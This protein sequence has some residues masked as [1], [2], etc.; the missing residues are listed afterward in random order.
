MAGYSGYSMSNNAIKAYD[1]GKLPLSKIT[2]KTL[3]KFNI[4]ISVEMFKWICQHKR[5]IC[6]CEWHHTSKHYNETN[7]YDL[8]EA[9]KILKGINLSVIEKEYRAWKA[10]QKPKEKDN[11]VYCASV[12]YQLLK[13]LNKKRKY[14]TYEDYAVICNGWAYLVS[15]GKKSVDGQHFWIKKRFDEKPEQIPDDLIAS[16]LEKIK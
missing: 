16:V 2:R 7:F 8:V 9:A 6:P 5:I 12:S 11:I 4:S 13:G 3:D 1:E 15:G 14:V 10:A